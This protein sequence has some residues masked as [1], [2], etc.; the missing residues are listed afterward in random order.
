MKIKYHII[1]KYLLSKNISD[2]KDDLMEYLRTAEKEI[3]DT[4]SNLEE[5][6]YSSDFQLVGGDEIKIE[7]NSILRS[8]GELFY[9]IQK[10]LAPIIGKNLRIGIKEL[11]ISFYR[12]EFELE[13]EPLDPIN[14]PFVSI[15][16]IKDKKCVIELED[17]GRKFLTR[18]YVERIINLI[19]EKI[20]RTY[21][22]GKGEYHKIVYESEQKE[23]L[24]NEDPT[25]QM[26][27]KDWITR[28]STKGKWIYWPPAAAIFK[29]ME[30]IV[31]EEILKP[32]EFQEMISSNIVSG[33]DIWL[34]TGHLEGMPM[35]LYYVAE[36]ITRNPKEWESF[37]DY[38]KIK[39]KVPYKQFY[40][41]VQLKPLQGLTYA[42]CPPIYNSFKGKTID[43]DRFPIF[44]FEREANSF[45]Y[46][47][48]GRHG[49]E[50][51]DE[52]H[53]IE[54]VFIGTPEQLMEIHKKLIDRY[55][56]IFNEIFEIEW[57]MANVTP[58]YMQQAGSIFKEGEYEDK[59]GTIDFEAW[60][61]YKGNR[62]ESEWLEFQ[63]ISIV[64]TKYID[65]FNI[66][67]QK[68]EKLWS[69]CTGIGL[70]RWVVVFLA[71]KG[72]DQE[73]WPKKFLEYLEKIP[74]PIKFY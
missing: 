6:Q 27:D 68:N 49:I 7:I 56:Y 54:A 15:L 35:E 33:E 13:K 45:R 53:R 18:N 69:G 72:L 70:E 71:Q 21:Y 37:I 42:Q 51:V 62:S 65:A 55:K 8:G 57:R 1:G 26:I 60:L 29:T 20:E 64:G 67:A 4:I 32:L 63:N 46:E 66:K 19:E 14:V 12:V 74:D 30:K 44:L 9:R 25:T 22:E 41:M 39:N 43:S 47:S 16:E 24:N 2:K 31:V 3:L 61:P 40:K 36:P 52:F 23:P 38:I 73:K 48:G 11:E 10:S 50:R 17:I 28:A 34:K 5:I 59:L 58:F